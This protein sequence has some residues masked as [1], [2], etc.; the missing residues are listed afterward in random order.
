MAELELISEKNNEEPFFMAVGFYKPHLPFCAPLK[1]WEMYSDEDIDLAPNKTIPEGVD[2]AFIYSSAEFRQQYS[3]PHQAGVGIVLPDEY[4]RDLKHA[5][6]AAISYT[7]TQVGK[8]LNKLE[9]LGLDENTIIVVWG[10]HGWCLGDHTIWGKHNVFDR[11]LNSTFMI[12]TPDMNKPGVASDQLIG[13]IDIYP[14]ICDL[15]GITPPE[16]IDGV[17]IT[18]IIENPKTKTRD[19]IYTYWQGK[20]SIKTKR[21]RLSVHNSRGKE[22]IMLFD[23]K[24]DPNETI[25][26]AEKYPK[27]T[28]ELLSKLKAQN[29]GY[30]PD[31]K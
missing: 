15:A 14:T 4:A 1:Y 16:G 25:N 8:V 21:Y 30:L 3:H 18:P 13:T 12:K 24:N 28:E 29:R 22:A 17:S 11:A 6:Y 27:V 20:L 9:E 2:N 19:E 23:H 26:A 10:D 7:D 5:Y 31:F